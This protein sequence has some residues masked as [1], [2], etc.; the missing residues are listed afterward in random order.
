VPIV[1]VALNFGERAIQIGTPFIT[2]G[3]IELD[4]PA[5][6]RSFSRVRGRKPRS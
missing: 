6:Q 2:S 4:L 1:P 3:D 5:L